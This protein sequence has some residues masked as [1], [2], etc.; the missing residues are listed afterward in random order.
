[1]SNRLAAAAATK[2]RSAMSMG[3]SPLTPA[4][5]IRPD[6]VICLQILL[7]ELTAERA[8]HVQGVETH[9]DEVHQHGHGQHD[10]HVALPDEKHG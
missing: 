7:V 5:T 4:D 2:N 1:M 6:R 3:E 8:G 9:R 10:A